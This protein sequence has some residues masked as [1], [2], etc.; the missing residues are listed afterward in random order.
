MNYYSYQTLTQKLEEM[1]FNHSVDCCD[2]FGHIFERDEAQKYLSL[3]S[4]SLDE[5][6]EALLKVTN[7]REAVVVNSFSG[8]ELA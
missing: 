1:T 5:K 3:D 4:F 7:C 6:R 8:R 2:D